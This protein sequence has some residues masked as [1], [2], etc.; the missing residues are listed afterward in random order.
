[1]GAENVYIYYELINITQRV[2]FW[3]KN[4]KCD[5][6]FSLYNSLIIKKLI[7]TDLRHHIAYFCSISPTK[8]DPNKAT[9]LFCISKQHEVFRT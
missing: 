7:L 1:M 5:I 3:C 6:D 4:H 8:V 2:T 9:A